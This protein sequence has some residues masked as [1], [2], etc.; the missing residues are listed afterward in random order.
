[1][2]RRYDPAVLLRGESLE[3]WQMWERNMRTEGK[4]PRT[5]ENRGESAAQLQ[6]WLDEHADGTQLA[7]ATEAQVSDYLIHT[8][9]TRSRATQANRHRALRTFYNFLVRKGII[10]RS[11]LANVGM[12]DPEY[13]PQPV[14]TDE[15][16]LKLLK[17]C[18]PRRGAGERERFAGLRDEAIIRVWCEPGSPR[19]SELCAMTLADVDL[20]EACARIRRGKGGRFRVFGLCTA[21]CEALWLYK[22]A[23]AKR[24]AAAATEALWLG[25][26]GP[27]TISGLGQLLGRRAAA[28]GLPPV[29][30]HSLRN[31]AY[32]DF[33]A[34]GGSLNDAMA[35][36][37]W[38]HP[39]MALHYGKQ[40]RARRAVD[41]SRRLARGDRLRTG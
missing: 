32:S 12:C 38:D 14:W 40:A 35:L 34:A 30:P 23:R 3:A 36:F 6:E 10:D 7:D 13:K 25:E 28:A 26:R 5:I 4:S 9:E 18:A 16:L 24:P 33:D 1:M 20:G 39:D 21:T 19:L 2:A 41:T 27:L 15:Q 8:G 17:A 29:N 31:T 37:G 22:R 11:P